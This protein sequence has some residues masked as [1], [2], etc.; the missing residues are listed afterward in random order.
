MSKEI[1][2]TK[3]RRL[4]RAYYKLFKVGLIDKHYYYQKIRELKQQ[5][6]K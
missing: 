4:F 5:M 3:L 6:L 2:K 1:S